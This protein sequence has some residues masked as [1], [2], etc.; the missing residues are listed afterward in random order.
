M[1][2]ERTWQ[3]WLERLYNLHRDKRESHERPHKPALLLAILDLVDK[4]QITRNEVPLNEDLVKTFRRYFEVVRQR[5]DKPTIENPYYF[6]SGDGFWALEKP[7][8]GRLYEAGNATSPPSMKVL[9]A[10]PGRFDPGLWDLLRGPGSR[11]RV[12]EALVDRYFPGKRGDLEVLF[13]RAAAAPD[14]AE[15]LQLNESFEQARSAAFRQVVLEVYDYMCAACGLRV[16][17]GDGFSLVDAAHLIPFE[18]SRD[19]KP[20]NGLALCPNHHRAMDR[21]LIAPCPDREHKAGVWRVSGRVD[22]RKDSR[23]DLVA[24]AGRPVLEPSEVKFLPAVESLR[25]REERFSLS[26]EH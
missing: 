7:S 2:S 5:D 17:L 26:I 12:R 1:P 10:T 15:A 21:N 22:E 25:W 18:V 24:L 8:G 6:L 9:R 3:Q 20:N 13:G 23:R 4:G 14:E 19:D 16:R 11:R